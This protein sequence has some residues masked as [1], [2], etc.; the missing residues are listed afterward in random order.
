MG[1]PMTGREMMKR[2][3]ASMAEKVWSRKLIRKMAPTMP[4]PRP[5]IRNIG[6]SC[7][8]AR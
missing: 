8:Q 7:V 1:S 5:H 6:V 4:M 3:T 2:P